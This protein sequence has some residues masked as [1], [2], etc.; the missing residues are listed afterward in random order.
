MEGA[1]QE[2]VS[3]KI[4]AKRPPVRQVVR[5]LRRS[6]TTFAARKMALACY[7]LRRDM[8]L[9][10]HQQCQP[11]EG[12]RSRSV[13]DNVDLAGVEPGLEFLQRH[14]ELEHGRFALRRVEL[15]RFHQRRLVG[16]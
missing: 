5:A 10:P 9:L 13:V 16:L 6:L 4:W 11:R 15:A 8:P 1:A 3:R 12:K 14:F 2:R 7:K